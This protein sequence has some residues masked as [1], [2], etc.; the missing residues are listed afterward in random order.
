MIP[1]QAE[2]ASHSLRRNACVAGDFTA[3]ASHMTDC[4]RSRG[5]FFALLATLE[6]LHAVT[7]PRIV[8]TGAVCVVFSLALG[9][10][11]LA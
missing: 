4:Q 2:A 7:A 3:L 5:R 6:T 10:L 1:T 9:L 8:T 11:T